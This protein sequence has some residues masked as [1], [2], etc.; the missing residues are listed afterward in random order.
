MG[1][2]YT[3]WENAAD[4]VPDRASEKSGHLCYGKLQ[5]KWFD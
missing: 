2:G 1:S 3:D 5:T 4:A